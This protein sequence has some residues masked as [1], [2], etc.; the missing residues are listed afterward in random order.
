[1]SCPSKIKVE[2]ITLII[3]YITTECQTYKVFVGFLYSLLFLL[4]KS[5]PILRADYGLGCLFRLAC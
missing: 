2:R 1:M 5:P 3:P 4:K